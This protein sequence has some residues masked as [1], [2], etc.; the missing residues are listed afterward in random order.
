MIDDP[1]SDDFPPDE[2][3]VADRL[4]TARPLP[5]PGFRGALARH[6]SASDPGYGPRPERLR[7]SVALY[8]LGGLLLIGLGALLAV[9][10]V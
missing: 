1:G 6:L 3:E 10:A 5:S 4:L 2:R 9:S 7:L 8:L